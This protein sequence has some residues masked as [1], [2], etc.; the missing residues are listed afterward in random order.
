MTLAHAMDRP[1]LRRVRDHGS[2]RW[3]VLAVFFAVAWFALGGLES[4]TLTVMVLVL[5]YAAAGS[6]FNLL[7]GSLGVFSLAQPVFVMVGGYTSAYLF[8]RHEISPWI[9]MLVAMVVAGALALPIG[10]IAMR[11]SGTIVTALV[12]LILSQA[13]PPIISAVKPLGGTIGLY[14]PVKSGD[15]WWDMQFATG[16]PFARILLVI[17]VVFIAGLMWFARSKWGGWTTAIR[18][19]EAAARA[20]GIPVLRVRITMF[21][22]SA[23]MASL[24][25]VV[26]AQYNLLS[27]TELFLS[28]SALFQVLVVAL[29]GGV[30]RA[31]GTL[32]GAV[33]MV[34]ISHRLSEAAGGRPGIGPLTFAGAFLIMALILP[35]GISGAWAAVQARFPGENPDVSPD[36]NPTGPADESV[37][38]DRRSAAATTEGARRGS[39]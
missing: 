24:P 8:A 39:E 33:L 30:D 29:V 12:T 7:F 3:I 4:A 16:V 18:D 19:S 36:R 34:E 9:S 1:A 22:V 10:F 26:Y 35:R 25:G 27:N 28:T 2:T 14:I 5:Y 21:V 20:T 15:N 32:V 38:D 11:R 37:V 13:A 23:M 6:S 17:N 31:W